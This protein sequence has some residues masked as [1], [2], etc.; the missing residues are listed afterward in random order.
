MLAVGGLV[1]LGGFT[2]LWWGWSTAQNL[3]YGLADLTVP[4]HYQ[5]GAQGSTTNQS[6][7]TG[8]ASTGPKGA[9]KLP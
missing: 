3:G 4:G 8:S 5:G 7:G 2:L 1:V 9:T 6:T